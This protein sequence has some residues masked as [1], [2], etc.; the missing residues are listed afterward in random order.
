[1]TKGMK[2][3]RKE[4]ESSV[5]SIVDPAV[6]CWMKERWRVVVE[7]RRQRLGMRKQLYD[8]TFGPLRGR[9][10]VKLVEFASDRQQF[11]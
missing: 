3:E 2:E 8:V 5:P 1:M 7:N 11:Y 6:E 4:S 9:D 10:E